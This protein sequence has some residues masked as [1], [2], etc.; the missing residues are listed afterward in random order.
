[1]TQQDFRQ[2]II[3]SI[4]P[5]CR[6]GII[7]GGVAG[8]TAA[9]RLS[10]AGIVVTLF[11]SGTSLVNGPPIC[12]LH[13]G[14]NLYR[15]ISN[16]QCLTLLAQS[17][18]MLRAFPHVANVRPTV[19]AVPKQDSGSPSDLLPRLMLLQQ[20]YQDLVTED[21][22]NTVLGNPAEYFKTYDRAYLEH[23]ALQ[24]LPSDPQ[25]L[26][27]WMIPVAKNVSLDRF[28]YPMIL[29]QECGLSL[30]R[31]AATSALSLSAQPNTNL[32]FGHRVTKVISLEKG[33]LIQAQYWN[34]AIS[35]WSLAEYEVDYLINAAGYQTGTIDDWVKQPQTRLV[36]FKAAYVTQWLECEGRWPEVIFHG[37]RGTP[38]G[39]AQLT[40]YA[41]N[42][43]QLHG[44]TQEI[45]LFNDGLVRSTEKSSQP[46]LPE[47]LT[48]R[49][50]QGWSEDEINE[51]TTRAVHHVE[52]YVPNFHSATCAGKPL[53]GAQ[54]VPGND[55]SLRAANVSFSGSDYARL[56]IVK[57]SSA[58]SA[59]DE[60]LKD[61]EHHSLIVPLPDNEPREVQLPIVQG[62]SCHDI[63]VMAQALAIERGYPES[64]AK[65]M[66]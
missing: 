59:A 43:F 53:F 4:S 46:A 51:R 55:I 33:W 48:K 10:E 15:E 27:D 42:Y 20:A 21:P 2:Q 3:E 18:D 65:P 26:D 63:Y 61:L 56:E 44:M 7:G 5:S 16:Q 32:L 22:R 11:E 62:L 8:S 19:I 17:I 23:L 39:M 1:M 13:A 66:S 57:A 30:F 64:L 40:P 58:L 54:Q 41:D 60:I 36:E 28:Q 6:V 38:Q 12:H 47:Y 34:E 24:P 9:M 25:T 52:Q 45:T 49:I 29:V 31:F 14:G 50:S 35:D 37:E